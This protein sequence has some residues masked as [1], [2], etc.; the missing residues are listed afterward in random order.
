MRSRRR[1]NVSKIGRTRENLHLAMDGDRDRDTHWCTGLNSLD[2]NE[3]Q[4]EGK[5]EQIGRTRRNLPPTMDGDRE[6]D[7]HWSTGLS[8]QGPNEEQKEGEHE[9]GNQDRKG[10]M[11]PLIQGD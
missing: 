1:E 10:C 5:R 8:L 3:K 2:P 6:G 11:Y 7:P 9:K 4:K